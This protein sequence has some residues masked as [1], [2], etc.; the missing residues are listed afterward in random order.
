MMRFFDSRAAVSGMAINA[1][2]TIEIDT[3]SSVTSS[4]SRS[5]GP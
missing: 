4:P 2:S 3:S 1:P 5:F